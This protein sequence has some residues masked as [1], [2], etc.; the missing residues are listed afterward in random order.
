MGDDARSDSPFPREVFSPPSRVRSSLS[1]FSFNCNSS[2]LSLSLSLP[3]PLPLPLLS[4]FLKRSIQIRCQV[5]IGILTYSISLSYKAFNY[6]PESILT[7]S[8]LP[9]TYT[10]EHLGLLALMLQ[11]RRKL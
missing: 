10:Q 11:K 4:Y 5:M 9:H 1:R 8:P 7:P 2:I 3:I 6:L